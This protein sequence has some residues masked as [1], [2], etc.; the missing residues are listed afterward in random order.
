VRHADQS[1]ELSGGLSYFTV[2]DGEPLVVFPGLARE[3]KH[4]A[5]SYRAL[6]HA[7]GRRIYVVNR[8]RGLRRGL[9]MPALAAAHAR[10]LEAYFGRAVDVFGVS[11]GGA[12]AL[13]LAVDAPAVTRRLIVVAAASWLG[14]AGRQK[15]RK[16]GERVANG[17]SGAAVLASVLAPPLLRWIVAI[18][19]WMTA[20]RQR[21]IDPGDMLATI[22]AECDFDVT[23]RLGAI[24]VPTL[25]IAGARDHAFSPELFRATAAG[26]PGAALI[27]YP[28][29]GHIGTMLH[30]RFGSDVAA[31][32]ARPL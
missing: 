20:R 12:I 26:I 7:T 19:I 15:L 28:R 16:Y 29:A 8:P 21:A 4:D 24:A 6:A 9:T 13:Q 32:L 11:T 1:S 30:P 2:G 27:L 5:F 31:F 25:V 14:E 10:A 18:G 22:D 17:H 3:P 23:P